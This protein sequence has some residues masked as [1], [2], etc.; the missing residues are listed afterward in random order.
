[1]PGTNAIVM[2]LA[3][4]RN[5]R[6]EAV[7]VSQ[8]QLAGTEDEAISEA[9]RLAELHAGAVVWRRESHPAIGEMGEPVILFQRGLVG[10]FN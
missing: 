6:G 4:D 8:P 9:D 5:E 10:D 2:F 7:P 3:F 1:M